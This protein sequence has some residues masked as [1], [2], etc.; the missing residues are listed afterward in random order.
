MPLKDPP[1]IKKVLGLLGPIYFK[2]RIRLLFGLIALLGVNFLQLII[3]RILKKGI[4]ALA[5][6][7]A[8]QNNLLELALLICF[9]GVIATL[10]RF[11]WRYLIIGFSRYLER[12]L[13]KKIFGHV[14]T[15][16]GS[17]FSKYSTGSI[18]AHGSNDLAAV[19]MACGMGLVAAIDA[20]VMSIAAIAFMAN[21]HLRLTLLALLPMPILALAT[22]Y[23]SGQLHHRFDRVQGQ[24]ASMTEFARSSIASIRLLKAYTLETSQSKRFAHLGQKYVHSSIRVAIIQGLL[25]P[26]ATLVGSFGMLLVLYFGGR[27]VILKTITMGDFVAFITYLYMLIWPIMAV[28]WVANLS[29]RGATSLRRIYLLL[30]VPSQL[31]P[32]I[33]GHRPDSSLFHLHRLN[34]NYPES[35][36]RILKDI[37]L[38]IPPGILGVTGPTGCGKTS[39]CQVLA[40]V[41]P[42]ADQSLFL[43]RTDIN[44]LPPETVKSLI[45]YVSQE[46]LL[47]SSCL[48]DNIAFGNPDASMERIVAAAT[49]AA[50]H[51]EIMALP[52][53]YESMIGEKGVTLSGGQRGRVALARAIL[54]DRP[55]IIIDDGLAAVDTST[56]QEIIENI[57]PWLK[58]K[59]VVWVSQRTKQLARTDRVLVLENG[60]ISA[61]GPYNEVVRENAFLAEISRRQELQGE[62][63]N[64]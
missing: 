11:S 37:T 12:D 38:D 53:G 48:R 58:G 15:M 14:M 42:I 3:P 8:N 33:T 41:Y 23:L 59:S 28:G 5:D 36:R 47:F 50:V 63:N 24:F 4:D 57:T 13:R 40:R 61:L 10:L 26:I 60:K 20:L 46:A 55:I 44:D 32:G 34:F 56:E 16:D 49:A 35:E 18:M 25:F 29:Q 2:H 30:S 64:A 19:Q 43:G 6:G 54:C 1:P 21:I 31:P 45:S 39:L 27:L 22:R 52:H 7:T 62:G 51:D 17:F 9:I